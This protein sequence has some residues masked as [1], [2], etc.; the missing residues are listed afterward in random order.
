M[1]PVECY[2]SLSERLRRLQLRLSKVT[3]TIL[4]NKKENKVKMFT[5]VFRKKVNVWANIKYLNTYF[6][7]VY[8]TA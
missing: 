1:Q 5:D 8:A 4:N 3:T 7:I 6:T 2:V